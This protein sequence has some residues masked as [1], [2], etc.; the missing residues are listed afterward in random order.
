LS[1]AR[2]RASLAPT[3]G[4]RGSRRC[5]CHIEEQRNMRSAS[6]RQLNALLSRQRCCSLAGPAV[7]LRGACRSVG[8]GARSRCLQTI[9]QPP[10]ARYLASCSTSAVSQSAACVH[11]VKMSAPARRSLRRASTSCVR[12]SASDR[13]ATAE[14]QGQQSGG[15]PSWNIK[16]LYDGT[17]FVFCPATQAYV[18]RH[19]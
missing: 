16:M 1:F 11:G 7:P 9:W 14:R 17:C 19:A 3:F 5:H 2:R 10:S 6:V 8:D 18:W 15:E 13:P 4:R 12:A